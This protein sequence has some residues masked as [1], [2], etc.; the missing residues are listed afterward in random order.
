MSEKEDML[1]DIQERFLSR[2]FCFFSENRVFRITKVRKICE[3]MRQLARSRYP[4]D[5]I[6]VERVCAQ[7]LKTVGTQS[8]RL[9]DEYMK[10]RQAAASVPVL[11]PD[12]RDFLSDANSAIEAAVAKQDE[13][14]VA[15]NNGIRTVMRTEKVFWHFFAKALFIHVSKI[16][17]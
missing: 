16:D 14:L 8:Q 2:R 15:L 10:N 3:S 7:I 5:V 4:S 9:D 11:R 1:T 12:S 13:S 17:C 6:E